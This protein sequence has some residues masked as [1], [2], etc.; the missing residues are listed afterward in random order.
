M[1]NLSHSCNI[2]LRVCDRINIC[3]KVN[4]FVFLRNGKVLGD[5][6]GVSG[7]MSDTNM[8]LGVGNFLKRFLMGCGESC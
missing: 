2:L 1:S 4:C 5:W 7:F 6:E 8:F 3:L